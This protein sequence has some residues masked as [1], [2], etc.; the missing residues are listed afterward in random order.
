MALVREGEGFDD[1]PL[2]KRLCFGNHPIVGSLWVDMD[3]SV[4]FVR[5][6]RPDEDPSEATSKRTSL[7]SLG[8][9]SGR[10][11]SRRQAAVAFRRL[12]YEEDEVGG[13]KEEASSPSEGEKLVK[14][15]V[16][17]PPRFRV[18]WGSSNLKTPAID[19][20]RRSSTS[21]IL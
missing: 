16:M 11:R 10:R 2:H 6:S 12:L 17:E 21:L 5:E 9:S 3:E 13:D 14:E 15:D 8:P 7:H 20:L 1:P 4:L 19:Q 18:D